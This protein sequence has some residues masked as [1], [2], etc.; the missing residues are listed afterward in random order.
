[1]VD[2]LNLVKLG[3]SSFVDRACGDV[4][5]GSLHGWTLG[6]IRMLLQ[7]FLHL[8]L[9]AKKGLLIDGDEVGL[10]PHGAFV[11]VLLCAPFVEADTLCSVFGLL[12][13]GFGFWGVL[14]FLGYGARVE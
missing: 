5:G 6:V 9:G 12:V 7:G 13:R 3:S 1:M 14:G 4:Q 2:L 11:L 10:G 8:L